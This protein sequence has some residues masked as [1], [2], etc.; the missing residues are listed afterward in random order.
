LAILDLHRNVL[1]LL[2]LFCVCRSGGEGGVSLPGVREM[3]WTVRGLLG[4]DAKFEET[5]RR[6]LPDPVVGA[7]LGF[8]VGYLAANSFSY[9]GVDAPRFLSLACGVFGAVGGC[10]LG[11]LRQGLPGR[12]KAVGWWSATMTI[13]V[14]IVSLVIGFICCM[15]F[16]PGNLSPL[17][18]FF[19]IGPLGAVLGIACGL[20]I[21]LVAQIPQLAE[22][23]VRRNGP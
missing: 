20:F 12:G 1:R 13:S 19:V 21:G 8:I 18:A 16:L 23:G 10:V 4:I 9:L 5:A 15:L 2:G 17:L 14:G 6:L 22:Q 7:F 11:L 3:K